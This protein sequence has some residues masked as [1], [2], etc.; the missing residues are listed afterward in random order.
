MKKILSSLTIVALL[1]AVL[2]TTASCN[3][4]RKTSR[5]RVKTLMVTGNYMKPRLLAELGQYYTKQP[6]LLFLQDADSD[7]PR[8]YYLANE[9]SEEIAAS[10]FADF[11]QFLNPKTI[12]VL[13]DDNCVPP[14][15]VKQAQESYRVMVLNSADWE[16]NAQMLGE[17]LDQPALGREF[18]DYLKRFEENT[19]PKAAK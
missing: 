5:A 10:K 4:F 15:Y 1:C 18:K 14:A 3:I 2:T 6:I 13:G 17:L 8:L 7:T 11:I 9:K 19:A 16:Q 12:V